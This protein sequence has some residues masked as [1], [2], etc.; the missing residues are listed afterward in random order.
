MLRCACCR[1]TSGACRSGWVGCAPLGPGSSCPDPVRRQAGAGRPAD[2]DPD[3]PAAGGH[4]PRQRARAGQRRRLLPGHRPRPSHH[5]GGGLRGRHLPDRPDHAAVRRSATPSSTPCSPHRDQLNDNLRRI[6]DE[7]T[8]PW[9]I[10]VTIVEIKDVEI[11]EAM[12]RAMA[13]EAEAERERRAK[14]IN[15]EGEFQASAED[16]RRRGDS[17]REPGV[18]A[19]AL[20]AD[21]ARARRRQ[22]STI[23]F[24][25]PMDLIRP[26]L[27]AWQ[28]NSGGSG[29]AVPHIRRVRSDE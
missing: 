8:E 5:R 29:D 3:H 1:S 6:I 19:A 16:A 18:A 4:H 28:G 27:E 23:V 2:R 11:P 25:L 10:K 12:Q 24:P 13:R 15:A 17:Q 9:G 7:Q 14:I 26:F 20:P 22:N 21:P